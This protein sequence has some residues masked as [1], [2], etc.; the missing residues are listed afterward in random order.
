MNL[1][2]LTVQEE[3]RALPDSSR[4]SSLARCT[5][6]YGQGQKADSLFLLDEGLAKLTRVNGSGGKIVLSICGPGQLIGEESLSEV[7]GSYCAEAMTITSANLVRIPRESALG[8]LASSGSAGAA[9][10]SYLLDRKLSLAEKVELLCLHDVEHRIL[11]YLAE[12]SDLLPGGENGNGHSIPITQLELADLIGAT[13]E[14][15]STTLN[16][17]ERRGLLKLSRRLLTVPAPAALREAAGA[18]LTPV[19]AGMG[20]R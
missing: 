14:T 5:V 4:L 17:L 19:A 2:K 10:V 16:Q 6:V 3:L 1:L 15:T 9:L 18:R 20:E 11:H 12:L 8:L 7:E 13:R